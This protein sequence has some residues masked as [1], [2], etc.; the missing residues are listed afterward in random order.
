MT[1]HLIDLPKFKVGDIVQQRNIYTGE[2]IRKGRVTKIK[3]LKTPAAGFIPKNYYEIEG[4]GLIAED[5]LEKAIKE[6]WQITREEFDKIYEGSVVV[7]NIL[8][9]SKR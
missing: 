9:T 4:K 3:Q 8:Y 5:L 6:P 1:E 7:G 2:I